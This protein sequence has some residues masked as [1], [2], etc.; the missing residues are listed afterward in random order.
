M[1]KLLLAGLVALAGCAP[2][3]MVAGPN[4]Q[5]RVYPQDMA[6]LIINRCATH[7]N[8]IDAREDSVASVAR[9]QRVRVFIRPQGQSGEAKL[10]FDAYDEKEEYEA[11]THTFRISA[12]ETDKD[13]VWT[14]TRSQYGSSRRP[15]RCISRVE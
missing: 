11:I 10:T 15:V 5:M 8:I 12:R 6:I 4:G 2:H 9:G 13:Y 14:L 7:S 3:I 1:R